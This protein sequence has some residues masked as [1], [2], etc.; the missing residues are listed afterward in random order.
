MDAAGQVAILWYDSV[1]HAIQGN[2]EESGI[3]WGVESGE[4]GRAKAVKRMK[5]Y[6]GLID[7]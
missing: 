7:R 6:L 1:R 5:D 3:T 2:D 4:S